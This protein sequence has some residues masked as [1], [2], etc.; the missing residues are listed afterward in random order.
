M[1]SAAMRGAGDSDLAVEST[2]ST[3]WETQT[4]KNVRYHTPLPPTKGLRQNTHQ[5]LA[6][7]LTKWLPLSRTRSNEEYNAGKGECGDSLG[8]KTSHTK[9]HKHHR[10]W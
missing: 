8:N 4:T 9:R 1:F 7:A 2:V 10:L 5:N 3:Q 6:E